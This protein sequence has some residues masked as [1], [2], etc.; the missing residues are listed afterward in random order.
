MRTHR[1]DS[2]S[3]LAICLIL[4]ALTTGCPPPPQRPAFVPMDEAI[5]RVNIN[6][7]LLAPEGAG[8]KGSPIEATGRLRR[9]R[10][11]SP[12][13]FSLTG[14]FRFSK[15]RY[16]ILL[17]RDPANREAL[18]A[19]TNDEEF[20][21]LIRPEI[22]TLW[23]GTFANLAARTTVTAEYL[24][25]MPFRPDQLIEVLGLTELPTDTTGVKGP[26]YRPQDDR[27]V[28]IFLE[29]DRF[30]QAYIQ[31]EY[32]LDPYQPFL[33][34]EIIFRRPDG[35]PQ[36]HAFLSDYRTVDKTNAVA[37]RK[38]R[39]EWPSAD[40]WLQITIPNLIQDDGVLRTTNPRSL[41]VDAARI[42]CVDEWTRPLETL[43]PTTAP[44]RAPA[45]PPASQPTTS[46]QPARSSG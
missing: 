32:Y 31:K 3:G 7:A 24:E 45:S 16:F 5:R 22:N 8:L 43:M 38:I 23:W 15:P 26:I 19:G 20:W 9:D 36:M 1:I 33:V 14:T 37:A 40:S 21:L 11:T 6:N 39:F 42:V 44:T 30:D 10:D 13:S 29:Y 4:L 2:L 34:R 27:N 25:E 46:S 28:L 41:G 17:L 18:Q 12:I 35:K